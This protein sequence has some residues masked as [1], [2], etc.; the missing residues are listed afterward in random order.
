MALRF[1][2]VGQALKSHCTVE[3]GKGDGLELG[4]FVCEVA[5]GFKIGLKNVCVYVVITDF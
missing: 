3:V 2:E 1:P 4:I 5:V